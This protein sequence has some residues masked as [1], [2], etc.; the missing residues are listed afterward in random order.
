MVGSGDHRLVAYKV[1]TEWRTLTEDQRAMGS[2]AGFK[3]SSKADFLVE[4]EVFRCGE[5]GCRVCMAGGAVG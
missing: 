1:P 4:Y 3:R 2:V 5:V